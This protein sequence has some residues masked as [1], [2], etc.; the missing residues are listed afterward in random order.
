[1]SAQNCQRGDLHKKH[2]FV[3]LST[4]PVWW[5]KKNK[6]KKGGEIFSWVAE[7]NTLLQALVRGLA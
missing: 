4:V 5:E 1:M 7:K 2:Q 6:K 3:Q